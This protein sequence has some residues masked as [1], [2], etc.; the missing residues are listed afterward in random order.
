MDSLSVKGTAFVLTGG[1]LD[2]REAKTTHG[3]IRGSAARPP[4]LIDQGVVA[5]GGAWA[6]VSTDGPALLSEPMDD[7]RQ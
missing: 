6:P 4:R 3:L 7:S 2:E 5:Y 1:I